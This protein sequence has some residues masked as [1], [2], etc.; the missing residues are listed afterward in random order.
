MYEKNFSDQDLTCSDCG[1]TFTFSAEE[2]AF[3]SER[4]FSSP[5]RCNECR[6]ARKNARGGSAP[7]QRYT[8]IC[9][10]CG[11]ETTVPFKPREDK[12]VYCSECFNKS[13]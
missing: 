5:K 12:P 3:Y 13:R 2:Q 9:D 1:A 4:G 10:E 8:V 6:T 7:K 11:V